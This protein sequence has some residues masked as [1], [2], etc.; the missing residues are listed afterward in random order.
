[1]CIWIIINF[2]F[3]GQLTIEGL[4]ISNGNKSPTDLKN[5]M[6]TVLG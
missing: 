2:C 1:M 3:Y 4:H 6:L 5:Y